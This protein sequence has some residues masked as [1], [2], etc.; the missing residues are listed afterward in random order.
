MFVTANNN[1]P[2]GMMNDTVV[3]EL[4]HPTIIYYVTKQYLHNTSEKRNDDKL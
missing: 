3:R 2:T 1:A 4:T